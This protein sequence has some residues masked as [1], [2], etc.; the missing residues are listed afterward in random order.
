MLCIRHGKNVFLIQNTSSISSNDY[1]S[2][3][4]RCLGPSHT[5]KEAVHHSL[6]VSTGAYQSSYSSTV[7][8]IV[9]CDQNIQNPL[10][11]TSF[12]F[13]VVTVTPQLRSCRFV[14][15]PTSPAAP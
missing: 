12:F 13:V 15:S 5:G 8:I 14:F 3:I 4:L 9:S 10:E 2:T 11:L 1:A 6:R 7:I